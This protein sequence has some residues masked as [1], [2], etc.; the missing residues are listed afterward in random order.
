MRYIKQEEHDPLFE[1]QWLI[2]KARTKELSRTHLLYLYTV[3]TLFILRNAYSLCIEY[4]LDTRQ[5]MKRKM[6]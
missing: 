5:G 1:M 3:A 6:I 2:I 4:V